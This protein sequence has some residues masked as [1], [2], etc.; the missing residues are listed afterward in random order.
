M[1][2]LPS[3]PTITWPSRFIPCCHLPQWVAGGAV[4]AVAAAVDFVLDPERADTTRSIKQVVSTMATR[5]R[6]AAGSFG[7]RPRTAAAA[8]LA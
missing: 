3:A 8:P 6:Q 2:R 1:E 7:S 4:A 5:W